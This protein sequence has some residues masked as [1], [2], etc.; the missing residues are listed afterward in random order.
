MYYLICFIGHIN[1]QTK[2][3][4]KRRKLRSQKVEYTFYLANDQFTRIRT[5][6]PYG[7]DNH[8]FFCSFDLE[9]KLE[10]VVVH[11]NSY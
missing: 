10:L 2:V 8:I 6:I 1:K 11:G 9:I 7:L 5:I 3:T 4:E